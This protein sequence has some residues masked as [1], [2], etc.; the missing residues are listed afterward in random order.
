MYNVYVSRLNRSISMNANLITL[1]CL[2]IKETTNSNKLQTKYIFTYEEISLRG[3]K[4]SIV[5]LNKFKVFYLFY[6]L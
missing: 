4:F 3:L 6:Q 1:D 2:N 5:L